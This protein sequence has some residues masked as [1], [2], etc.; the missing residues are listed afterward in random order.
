MIALLVPGF[1]SLADDN[2]AGCAERGIQFYHRN[3]FSAVTE[4]IFFVFVRVELVAH[5]MDR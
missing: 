3:I 4:K 5:L 2:T 1:D